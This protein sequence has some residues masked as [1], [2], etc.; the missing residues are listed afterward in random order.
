MTIDLNEI[1]REIREI[2]TS[3]QLEKNELKRHTNNQIDENFINISQEIL[4]DEKM[5]M[6]IEAELIKNMENLKTIQLALYY[7]E[8]IKNNMKNRLAETDL[9]TQVFEL[10]YEKLEDCEEE[11]QFLLMK[12]LSYQNL[13]PLC[14]SDSPYLEDA[15]SYVN[16]YLTNYL[17]QI[18]YEIDIYNAMALYINA[19][20][21]EAIADEHL[22]TVEEIKKINEF[23]SSHADKM[24]LEY[25]FFI[26]RIDTIIATH[27]LKEK[28]YMCIQPS[29]VLTQKEINIILS[30]IQKNKVD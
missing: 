8:K 11:Q 10:F 14:F 15:L 19:C 30:K 1:L 22:Q 17:S 3:L 5:L 27:S 13:L 29:E 26:N 24:S 6:Q 25:I 21:S 18:A 23:L 28:N 9:F 16:N 7:V 4:N 20:K 12:M 2:I